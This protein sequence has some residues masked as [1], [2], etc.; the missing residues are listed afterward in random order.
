MSTTTSAFDVPR[1]TA[2][3]WRIIISRVTGMVDSIPCIT[4]PRESPTRMKSQKGST[5]PAVCA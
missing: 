4:M 2:C 5:I 1:I 3:A